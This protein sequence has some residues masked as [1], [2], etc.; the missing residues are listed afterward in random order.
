[1]ADTMGRCDTGRD[2]FGD[3]YVQPMWQEEQDTDSKVCGQYIA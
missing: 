2:Q 3:M 1:M